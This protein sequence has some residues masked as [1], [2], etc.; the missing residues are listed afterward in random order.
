M[1]INLNMKIEKRKKVNNL[2]KIQTD[3]TWIKLTNIYKKNKKI[4]E[5][6][7][8]RNIKLTCKIVRLLVMSGWL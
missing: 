4:N 2:L 6:Q 8:D 5:K 7:M 1:E 3:Y